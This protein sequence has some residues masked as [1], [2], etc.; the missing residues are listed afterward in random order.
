MHKQPNDLIM[1]T[2]Q[3]SRKILRFKELE[4]IFERDR[5]K[6]EA[7]LS[8]I[9]EGLI[10]TYKDG[11][12]I[13]ANPLAEQA[14]GWKEGELVGKSL[15]TTHPLIDA[16]GKEVP[17][18]ERPVYRALHRG[19]RVTT[20]AYSYKM[21]NGAEVP[22]AITATPIIMGGK[23]TGAIQVFRDISKEREIER[24]KSELISL[25][26]HQLRTPL[27]GI[28][29]YVEALANEEIGKLNA[30]QKKYLQEV[31][32][33]N[34]KLV[35]LVYDFL[36]V[37]RIE[38]GTFNVQTSVVDIKATSKE[39]LDGLKPIIDAKKLEISE[40]YAGNLEAVQIDRKIIKLIL[41]NLITNSVK[42]TKKG[43]KIKI[44]ITAK[45]PL[46]FGS[47]KKLIVTI[48]DNGVG[49]P[50]KDRQKIFTK[51]FRA[52]NIKI[53]D[54][55]GT[56]LGLYLVKSFTELCGGK[57]RFK[58]KENVGTTFSVILPLS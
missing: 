52:D 15:F 48:A 5:D 31:H 36:N 34:K 49:I 18:E 22:F 32:R 16:S 13:L 45:T 50:K 46:I 41:Q 53:L 44:G 58:S 57:I 43:G 20:S 37:S 14:L 25:V 42:Y 35:E 7:I 11:R 56:G 3:I 10:A 47:A 1:K 24:T 26:S 39:A 4:P 27:S 40:S 28:N 51:L 38:L 6:D 19:E 9:G 2:R 33:A 21:K 12:I 30:E 29:W 54:T 23:I 55:D 8:S 17:A